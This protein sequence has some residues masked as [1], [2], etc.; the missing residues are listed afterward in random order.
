MGERLC[1]QT[2]GGNL[3]QIGDIFECEYC[4]R[5]Y[6]D[7]VIERAYKKLENS[8]K[9]KFGDLVHEEIVKNEQE[10]FRPLLSQL[11]QKSQEKYTDS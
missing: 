3:V 1:C 2:C 8:L 4:H 7:I 11:W 9:A 6:N 10:K 5:Q